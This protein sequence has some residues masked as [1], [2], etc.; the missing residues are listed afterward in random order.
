[1][2]TAPLDSATDGTACF[3]WPTV[4][5]GQILESVRLHF[6]AGRLVDASAQRG[7]PMLRQLLTSDEA[8]RAV[9]EIGL[10]CNHAIDQPL[11]HPL[12]D[13]KITGT[14]HVALGMALP[15]LGAF[16]Q[17]AMHFDLVADLRQGGRIEADGRLINE[18]GRFSEA[19]WPLE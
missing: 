14:F 10:G 18:N 15:G 12:V 1:M 7:E 16:A 17:P 4:C 9:G 3:G 2:F 6:R 11:G 19:I 8:G 5:G 13:E